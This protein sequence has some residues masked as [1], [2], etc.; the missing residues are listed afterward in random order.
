[1]AKLHRDI[2][3]SN[4]LVTT[5]GRLV[6]LDFGLVA[7]IAQQK[8]EPSQAI[9]GTP[10]YMS[11]E[12]M[13]QRPTSAAS[14]WYNAGVMLYEALTGHLPF[15]GNLVDILVKKQSVEPPPPREISLE[16]PEDLSSLCQGPVASPT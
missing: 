11:P 12:Q 2:K 6:I 13:A 16:V 10:S 9:V 3:P 5:E 14:D 4:I 15:D 7:D 1:M 8:L